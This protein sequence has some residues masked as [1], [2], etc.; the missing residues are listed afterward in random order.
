[1][2]G[3]IPGQLEISFHTLDV[4]EIVHT[5]DVLV[6]GVYEK[7]SLTWVRWMCSC[8]SS[9]HGETLW[10]DEAMALRAGERHMK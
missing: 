3:Q 7:R 10:S 6:H 1:M 2:K 5:Y 8:G 9:A 4:V